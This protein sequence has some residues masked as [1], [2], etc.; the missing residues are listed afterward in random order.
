MNLN[1]FKDALDYYMDYSD[2]DTNLVVRVPSGIEMEVKR[3]VMEIPNEGQIQ[4]VLELVA[5]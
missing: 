4:L 3:M 5:K 2:H 1:D